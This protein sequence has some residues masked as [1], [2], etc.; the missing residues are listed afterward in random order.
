MLRRRPDHVVA[1]AALAATMNVAISETAK[2]SRFSSSAFVSSRHLSGEAAIDVT[3]QTGIVALAWPSA[4]MELRLTHGAHVRR[5]DDDDDDLDAAGTAP[6]PVVA[7]PT[8]PVD[9]SSC[10]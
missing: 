4:V 2:L 3:C 9:H 10:C 5:Q 6:V 1:H 7:V 8:A